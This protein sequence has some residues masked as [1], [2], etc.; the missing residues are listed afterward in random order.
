MSDINPSHLVLLDRDG[1]INEDSDAYIKHPDEWHALPG[2]LETISKLNQHQIAVIVV[3]NQSGLGRGL[4]DHKTLDAIHE[5]MHQQLS[6]LGG[7]ITEVFYCP[8][9]PDENCNCRKPKTGMLDAIEKKYNLSLVNVPFI[10][11]TDKDLELAKAKG[12]LPIL[13]KTGKGKNYYENQKTQL[14]NTL[15][16]DNLEQAGDYL[17]AHRFKMKQE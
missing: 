7:H 12:C 17:L 16:F 8:H 6:R 11:D 2:S 3:S 10:G 14:E 15:V 1:V 13:V 4:F 9:K 5:K